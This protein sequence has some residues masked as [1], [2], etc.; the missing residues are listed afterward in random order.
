M[1]G[2]PKNKILQD[3]Q[4]FAAPKFHAILLLFSGNTKLGY[5]SFSQLV[6]WKEGTPK[7]SPL[8]DPLLMMQT[9]CGKIGDILGTKGDVTESLMVHIC[10]HTKMSNDFL[11]SSCQIK[12][13]KSFLQLKSEKDLINSYD[14]TRA[15]KIFCEKCASVWVWNSYMLCLKGKLKY[16]A[17]YMIL[18]F[19]GHYLQY[20]RNLL[21][22]NKKH[23]W[24]VAQVFIIP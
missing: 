7:V 21:W 6:L 11:F 20:P 4:S 10:E 17:N 14:K 8:G 3:V 12:A 15:H 2:S 9:L 22:D 5:E 13:E 24:M 1:T 23:N 18:D 19:K 16:T